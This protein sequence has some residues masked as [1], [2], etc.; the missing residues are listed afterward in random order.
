[1]DL[2]Q[3]GIW[4]SGLRDEDRRA[5]DGVRE[6][7]AELEELGYDAIWLGGSPGVRHA[8]PLLEAT[9]RIVVATGILNIW[10]Y[11][12]AEVAE[13][14]TALAER[15]PG[16]FLLG[17]GASHAALVKGY[18][19]PYSMMV[20]YLD[21]LDA[22]GSAKEHRVLAALGP[23]ML[24][25]SRDRA[26]GAHPYLIT[27][28]HTATAREILGP[29]SLLAPE[30]KVVLETDPERARAAA[31]GH[32]AIYLGMPNYTGNLLRLGFVD[33]DFR[34]GGSDRLIDATFAWGDMEAIRARLAAHREAGADQLVVQVVTGD[35]VAMPRSQWRELA[36]GLELRSRS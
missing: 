20:D 35:Q 11:E 12:P 36:D 4:N 13:E 9:E 8:A 29:D 19:K 15:H 34:D 16:R 1:M 7:A 27:P 23:R 22:A 21:R 25:L 31:R 3:I 26:A 33:D 18:R 10:E 24:T 2:G 30:V 5:A 14:Q 17:L 32:L 6:A 28:E